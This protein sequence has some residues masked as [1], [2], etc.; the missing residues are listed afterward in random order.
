MCIR[1]RI[2]ETRLVGWNSVYKWVSQRVPAFAHRLVRRTRY[3]VRQIV[4]TVYKDFLRTKDIYLHGTRKIPV[5]TY[6]TRVHPVYGKRTLVR[7]S[8]S[9]SEKRTFLIEV[10]RHYRNGR[11]STSRY[12]PESE[13]AK[14][15][16]RRSETELTDAC[17]LELLKLTDL[18]SHFQFL[19][20]PL[21][22]RN[23]LSS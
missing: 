15:A 13:Q 2:W 12:G 22:S 9:W 17:H 10:R 1:D 6:V 14:K 20:S 18:L 5:Y 23:L 11:V 4:R 21:R 19:L 16:I 7:T 8:M 3:G